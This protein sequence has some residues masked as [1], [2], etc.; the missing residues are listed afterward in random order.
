MNF[1][2]KLFSVKHLAHSLLFSDPSVGSKRKRGKGQFV[3][4]TG[5]HSYDTRQ[6]RPH[7][8]SLYAIYKLDGYGCLIHG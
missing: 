3:H 8:L 5:I 1:C 6:A 4:V 2:Y 7:S